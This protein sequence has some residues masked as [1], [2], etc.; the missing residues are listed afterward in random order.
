MRLGIGR[1]I[2][3]LVHR[4]DI[5]L[6]N[7]AGTASPSSSTSSTRTAEHYFP[8]SSHPARI[9]LY[10]THDTTILVFLLALGVFDNVW[11]KYT[12]NLSFELLNVGGACDWS[13]DW[14]VPL[15]VE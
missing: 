14:D 9:C 5:M 3:E 8:K 11:P 12:A 7:D 2:E 10:G 6:A 15:G 4:F 13:R 1:F